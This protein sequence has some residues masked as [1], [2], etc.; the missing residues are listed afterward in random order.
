MDTIIDEYSHLS[1]LETISMTDPFKTNFLTD[2][3]IMEVRTLDEIS[4]NDTHHHSTF[5][6]SFD[7]IENNLSSMF[8]SETLSDP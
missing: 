6:P 1:C 4:G 2:D 3:G 7:K 8:S 5:F